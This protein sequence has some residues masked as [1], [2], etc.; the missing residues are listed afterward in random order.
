MDV[1]EGAIHHL[2]HF[3]AC[4]RPWI[5]S[6]LLGA[7]AII[8]G[9]CASFIAVKSREL[10]ESSPFFMTARS[11]EVRVVIWGMLAIRTHIH[12]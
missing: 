5:G 6:V 4:M 12:G 11:R 9:W 1:G 7:C 8:L 2:D 10:K 3:D